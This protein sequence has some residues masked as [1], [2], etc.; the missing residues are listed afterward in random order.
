[1]KINIKKFNVFTIV[2]LLSLIAGILLWI[3]WG[4]RFGVW[5]DIGIYAL[6]IILILAGIIGTIL[7]LLEEKKD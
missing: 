1:M 4:T 3:W 5:Y 7:S 6:T 2:S